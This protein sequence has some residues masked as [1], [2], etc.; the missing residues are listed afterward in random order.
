MT[1]YFQD[2]GQAAP[3]SR[4]V[5]T[6][7]HWAGAAVSLSL[8]A[9]I[10]IWGFK[11]VARDV[12]GVPVV[13]AAE[14][15]MRIAPEDPGGRLAD[16]QGLSVNTV[17]GHG[18]AE[19]PAERLVIASRPAGLAEDDVAQGALQSYERQSA[20]AAA[21]AETRRAADAR[22]EMP[23]RAPRFGAP[24]DAVKPLPATF[25]RDDAVIPHDS[26]LAKSG[27]AEIQALVTQLTDGAMPLGTAA[28]DET[29]TPAA[30]DMAG[31]DNDSGMFSD[32]KAAPAGL[33]AFAGVRPQ[34]RPVLVAA[35]TEPVE[36]LNAASGATVVP[37]SVIAEAL[38]MGGPAA[39]EIDADDLPAGTRLVQIGAFDS[40][41]IARAEWDRLMGRFDAYLGDKGRVIQQAQSGG[42]TFYRLR[43]H[44][45]AD[46]SDARRFCA[47]FVAEGVDCI[48]VVSR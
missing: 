28:R 6:M 39:A 40:A 12:S 21:A 35:R 25:T 47:A 3:V 4:D 9:G 41:E 7:A 34:G 38:G 46:L 13:L 43:A 2:S 27:D 17:A 20:E 31:Q 1:E 15:P 37:G 24:G 26:P 48:P 10:G 29:E 11:L 5:A 36:I 45:F 22:T 8:I 14:G 32:A 33:R 30:P 18:V 44:G 23:G 42:R 16:H 19:G